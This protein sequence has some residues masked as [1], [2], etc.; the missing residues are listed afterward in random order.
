M[1]S[2]G[3]ALLLRC[4]V[5]RRITERRIRRQKLDRIGNAGEDDP[6]CLRNKMEHLQIAMERAVRQQ[7]AARADPNSLLP[8]YL[9]P[10]SGTT[11]TTSTSPGRSTRGS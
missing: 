4:N 11:T 3:H 6:V 5:R 1:P 8:R 10:M 9:F 2:F 7:Q